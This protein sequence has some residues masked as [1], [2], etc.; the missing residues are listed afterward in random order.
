ML[1]ITT[2]SGVFIFCSYSTDIVLQFFKGLNIT[3]DQKKFFRKAFH[4]YYDAA[5]EL[6]QSEHAVRLLIIE[7]T[8]FFWLGGQY[9]FE[10]RI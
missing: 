7:F 3:T 9:L 6:L 5:A 1:R 4:T 8:H 10:K 2:F